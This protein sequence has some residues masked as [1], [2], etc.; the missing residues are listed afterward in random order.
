MPI[1]DA[2]IR[3]LPAEIRR[4]FELY[5]H[6]VSRMLGLWLDRRP[7]Q[8]ARNRLRAEADRLRQ[9]GQHEAAIGAYQAYLSAR[10]DHALAW[11]MLG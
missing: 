6:S 8:R 5:D 11:C 10:P 1:R 2:L 4:G 3:R 7:W 9:A